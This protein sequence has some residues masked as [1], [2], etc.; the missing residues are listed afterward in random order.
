MSISTYGPAIGV[1]GTKL[2]IGTGSPPT[3]EVV[4]ALDFSLPMIAETQDVTNL[5]DLW[6]RR[7]PT[8]LDLGKIS[9]TIE[10]VM[11]EPTHMNVAAG[12][13]GLLI[14][15]TLAY[16]KAVYPQGSQP[17]L[18]FD[19]FAGYVV[20]FQITGKVGK[21]YEAKIEFSNSGTPQLV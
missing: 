11:E 21:V 13:R 9:F 2:L 10:W 8:L 14:N 7:F 20:A 18:P 12:L 1:L 4:N 15:Q 17:S 3:T 16:V 5:G 6:R 19:A